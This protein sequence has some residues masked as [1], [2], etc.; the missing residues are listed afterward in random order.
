MDL[1]LRGGTVYDG[2]GSPP[3]QTDIAIKNY[4]IAA[5][6][7]DLT[8]SEIIDISGLSVAPGFIDTH[9][10]SEFTLLA[11]PR[12]EGKVIQ[13]ITTEI[14]GNCGMSGGPLMG[15]A[16]KQRESDLLSYGITERWESLGEFL[17][18]L[19]ARGLV[20]NYATLVGH[21][22]IKASV[23]GYEDRKPTEPEM[24]LMRELLA[25]A[26]H[27]GAIGLSTGLI[28][29]P[30]IYSDTEELIELARYG[31]QVVPG[32]V[33][34][35]HMRS[36]GDYLL[37]AV[38]ETLRIGRESGALVHISHIKTS[39][40]ENWHKI[41]ACIDLMEEA[42][43][44]GIKVSCDRYPYTAGSTDLDAVFPKWMFEGGNN[45]EL[46]RLN[47][48]RTLARLRE[49]LPQAPELWDTI[50][51]ASVD[52]APN[53]WMEGLSV[54]EVGSRLNIHPIEACFSVL[55]DES[56][57]VGAIFHSMSEENLVRFLS[58]PYAMMGSDSSVRG[59]D[60]PTVQGKPHP[61][62][63]GSIPRY[64]RLHGHGKNPLTDSVVPLEKLIHKLT[65]LP[66]E[67]FSLRDRGVIKE[68]AIADLVVFSPE[69]VFD[70][71]S[72]QEPFLRTDG[73]E[74]V[75]V[76]GK[77]VLSEGKTTSLRP[78]CVIRGN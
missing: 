29:P 36:E 78:G 64:F 59:F 76:N 11:D 12:A 23:M 5:I 68:G 62:G 70:N 75:L 24:N 32:F 74:Y 49:E 43:K 3:I 17:H 56:L 38:Q 13:G 67:I 9:C 40:K 50:I 20:I 15:A 57:R 25:A 14:N 73:I 2:T 16:L 45:A 7:H 46:K 44:E 51:I 22:N 53:K 71:A 55:R 28:Y 66:A 61:R 30:G 26:L 4:R 58:L 6:G 37:D 48:E 34:T 10:H 35:S 47:D 69:D 65:G 19:E 60:G 21:G 77:V 39:G 52:T 1:I 33:Y 54:T 27:D 31:N 63:F 41:D 42:I 72:Y 8:G 18:I